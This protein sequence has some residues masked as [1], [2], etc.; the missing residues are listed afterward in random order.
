MSN[1]I[2]CNTRTGAVSEYSGHDFKSITPRHGTSGTGLC[3]FGGD[4][5]AEQPIVA[6]VQLPA[7][8]R[9]STLRQA[10]DMVYL[11]MRG[12]GVA[13]FAVLGSGAQRWSYEFALRASDVTRCPVG[14]GIK[15][16][17]LGFEL[18]TPS[19]QAFTLDRI[20][21]LNVKSKT[22]RV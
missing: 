9:E 8:L 4:T 20:E 21:V 13:Q 7:T 12:E 6:T 17:Y 18:S 2:I 19:G 14:R 10:I 22:R 11:S 5:D 3:A 1:T 15:E 16:N